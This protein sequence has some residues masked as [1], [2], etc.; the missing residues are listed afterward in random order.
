MGTPETQWFGNAFSPS[1]SRLA[2][3]CR[4]HPYDKFTFCDIRGRMGKVKLNKN[5]L[6]QLPEPGQRWLRKIMRVGSNTIHLVF[7]K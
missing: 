3:I 5:H 1:R 4:M 2:G 7:L 6:F